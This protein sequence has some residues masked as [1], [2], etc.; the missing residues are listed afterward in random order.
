MLVN[1]WRCRE[2]CGGTRIYIVVCF[3]FFFEVRR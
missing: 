2:G 1:D 3:F